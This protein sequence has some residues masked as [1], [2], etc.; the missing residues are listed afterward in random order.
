MAP[1]S[2]Q[3]L[4]FAVVG[5]LSNGLLFLAYLGLTSIAVSPRAAMTAVYAAGVLQTFLFNRRW[6]FQHRGSSR[7]ALVRYIATFVLGYLLNLGG[8]VLLVNRLGLPHQFVQADMILTVA[9]FSFFLQRYWVFRPTV[10][11][12]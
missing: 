10:K 2:I 11:S 8:L 3:L 12:L 6:T 9:A 5:F 1:L 4:R 7:A